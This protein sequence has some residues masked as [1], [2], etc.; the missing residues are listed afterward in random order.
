ME[1][2][3]GGKNKEEKT[4]SEIYLTLGNTCENLTNNQ[5]QALGDAHSCAV[6]MNAPTRSPSQGEIYRSHLGCSTFK[7]VFHGGVLYDAPSTILHRPHIDQ[8]L[9][10]DPPL[11]IF[12]PMTISQVNSM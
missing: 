5:W 8:T 6:V 10:A 9:L 7:V 11:E 2:K 3:A 1:K 12:L 4:Q